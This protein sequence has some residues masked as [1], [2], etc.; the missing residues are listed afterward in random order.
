[1]VGFQYVGQVFH[2]T[3]YIYFAYM[4][5]IYLYILNCLCE[6]ETGAWKSKKN[7]LKNRYQFANQPHSQRSLL[8]VPTEQERE[9]L[10]GS[11]HVAPEQN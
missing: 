7:L 1:M 3:L 4:F 6:I 9:T 11:G 5:G 10:L 2:S 8:P